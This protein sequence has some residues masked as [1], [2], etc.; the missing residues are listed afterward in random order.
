MKS[1]IPLKLINK[2]IS[3]KQ[4][5]KTNHYLQKQ[6]ISFPPQ[7]NIKIIAI[8]RIQMILL[9]T[10]LI[11]TQLLIHPT[12]TCIIFLIKHLTKLIPPTNSLLILKSMISMTQA[13]F[14][15]IITKEINKLLKINIKVL[16]KQK[17]LKWNLNIGQKSSTKLILNNT[18]NNHT[19]PKIN[20]MEI[21]LLYKINPF[22]N[23]QFKLQIRS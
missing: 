2:Q 18:I 15:P 4:M 10:A 22:L 6:I 12:K 16:L 13:C 1:K 9:I 17:S 14:K 11:S 19:N 8:N 5:F 23:I 7:S 20:I 21:P 3:I